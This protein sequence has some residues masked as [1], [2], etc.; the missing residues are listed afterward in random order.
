M[1]LLKRVFSA[2]YRRALAAEAAGE[3]LEAAR[4]YALADEKAKVAEMHLL[5]A[6]RAGGLEGRVAELR[7]AA[8]WAAEGTDEAL[9]VRRRIARA[10]LDLVKQAGVFADGD[11][12]LLHEA[13]QLFSS[14]GD[15]AGAGECL[16]LAGDE[17]AAADA[18]Q[19]AGEVE[20]LEIVLGREE[21]RRDH[22]RKL[23]EAFADY[24][25][26]LAAGARDAA[27]G[28]LRE[29]VQ[30]E[31]GGPSRRLLAELEP[32]LITGGAVALRVEPARTPTWYVGVFPFA[33]GRELSAEVPL[34]DARVSRRHAEVLWSGG[35][36]A[37]RDSRSRNGTLLSGLPIA[38]ELPLPPEGELGLGDAVSLSFRVEGE[39]L[40]LHVVRGT[41]RGLTAVASPAPI[42]IAEGAALLRFEDG[43][44][45]LRP[46][47]GRRILL[48]DARAGNEVQ[49]LRG[50]RIEVRVEGAAAEPVRIAVETGE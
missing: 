31:P 46:G 42:A 17:Q 32:R 33:I 4:A 8:R 29:C 15:H 38:G 36:F 35:R 2:D 30:L 14:A 6:E 34:R 49:L 23:R 50:D 47:P 48:N 39:L 41:D 16:E 3:Y 20:R 18:Y 7:T 11:R 9:A 24:Q 45:L 21:G 37:V 40:S 5:A 26:Q 10:L 13:A 25:L 1:S 22:A 19:H 12:K 28:R 44:P 43:R 27:I